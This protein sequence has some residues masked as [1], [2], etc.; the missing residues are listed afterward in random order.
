[1][2]SFLDATQN[3]LPLSQ[4]SNVL[5]LRPEVRN[6]NKSL[7]QHRSPP[8]SNSLGRT[9]QG[10]PPRYFYPLP[11]ISTVTVYILQ[12][13]HYRHLHMVCCLRRH[14]QHHSEQW[15]LPSKKLQRLMNIKLQPYMCFPIGVWNWYFL[16]ISEVL[17]KWVW[18]MMYLCTP[19][20][21]HAPVCGRW[22][23]EVV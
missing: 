17:F 6:A 1:M 3:G 4:N 19:V 10:K 13:M 5:F 12:S 16:V 11:G 22:W 7:N 14:T 2:H 23:G 21:A 20:L 9:P 15:P 18:P 8:P